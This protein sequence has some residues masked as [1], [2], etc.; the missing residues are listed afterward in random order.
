MVMISTTDLNGAL[1]I[2]D[3]S[4]VELAVANRGNRY[5]AAGGTHIY[6]KGQRQLD[7]FISMEP[8][9]YAAIACAG[10]EHVESAA[11]I[12]S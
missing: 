10:F 5:Q 8:E 11:R 7:I 4:D 2:F 6:L 9:A 3:T 12:V 1:V